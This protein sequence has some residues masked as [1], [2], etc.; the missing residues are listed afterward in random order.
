MRKIIF[1]LSMFSFLTSCSQSDVNNINLK[2]VVKNNKT[3]EP[4]IVKK[5]E[6]KIECW[7]YGNSTS[8][9]YG[10]FERINIETNDKGEFSK[11]F[12]KGALIIFII[13]AEGYKKFVKKLYLKKS[14]NTYDI[15]LIPLED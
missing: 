1:I 11:T 4:V 7:K 10:D 5:A 13:K 12:D 14:D 3:K 6:F 15:N 8:E 9:G 2:G